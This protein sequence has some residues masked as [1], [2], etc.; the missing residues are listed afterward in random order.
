MVF[1][2]QVYK[3]SSPNNK[4][5][6]YLTKRDFVDHVTHVDHIEG[7]LLL[8]PNYV[9]DRNVYVQ[10]GLSFRFGREED[11]SMGYNF[12]KSMYLNTTQIYPPCEEFET[13]EMQKNLMSRLGNF[14][15]AFKLD[16]PKLSSPSYT[17]MFGWE[18]VGPRISVEYEVMAFVGINDQDMHKRNS[19]NLV[20]RRLME[21]PIH[22]F[23]Y[24]PPDGNITKSFLTCSGSVSITASLTS[25]VY[26]PEEDIPINVSIKNHTSRDIKRLK[27]KIIQLSEV[28]M[29]NEQRTRDKTVIKVDDAINLTP[30]TCCNRDL[31]LSLLTP[32]KRATGHIFLQGKLRP[33]STDTLAPSTILNPSVMKKDIFGVHISYAV[34]VKATLGPLFGD[35]ILDIPFTLAARQE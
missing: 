7:V 9:Q 19:A 31:T 23:D 21:C 11:E 2:F 35:A 15:F 5:T 13:S 12:V 28:P 4:I 16:F 6:L 18:E 8:D 30:G 14:A 26:Y 20:I 25:P 32:S 1:K 34:R 22:V 3:K 24:P 17:M 27:V 10:L 33:E 29:F